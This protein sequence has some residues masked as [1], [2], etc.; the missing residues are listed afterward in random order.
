M[1]KC[2]RNVENFLEACRKI[3]V[4]Q[5]SFKNH[6]CNDLITAERWGSG[7]KTVKKPTEASKDAN[8]VANS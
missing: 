1:A 6:F 8:Q 2:R 5:V 7:G 3:G 4:P